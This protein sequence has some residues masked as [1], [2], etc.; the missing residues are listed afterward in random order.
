MRRKLSSNSMHN[1]KRSIL[2][3][4]NLMPQI[5]ELSTTSWLS[6]ILR[7]LRGTLLM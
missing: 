6:H 7:V 2:L 1:T 5:P 4:Y 3:E